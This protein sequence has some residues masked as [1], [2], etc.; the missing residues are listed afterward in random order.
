MNTIRLHSLGVRPE[1]EHFKQARST[2]LK[3][4]ERDKTAL[5]PA[6][7]KDFTI[8]MIYSDFLKCK[9]AGSAVGLMKFVPETR[10]GPPEKSYFTKENITDVP[11]VITNSFGKG[12]SVFIPWQLGS[13]YHFK[14]NYMHRALF[15]GAL[16]NILKADRTIITNASP[17]IE[18]SHMVNR[19]N[20]FE[21]IGL[22]NHS[23]Q[24]GGSLRE[25]VPVFN[26]SVRFKPRRPIK[27]IR[28]IRSGK[29]LEFKSDNGWV[30][31]IVPE[32]RDFE[33][34]VCYYR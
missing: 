29:S 18:M 14:G 16:Q 34:V 22:I 3:V 8:M 15:V 6:E 30:E 23:G 4:S 24:I 5:G 11:G 7:F 33:M 19:N 32:V 10:F 21:W 2:Y 20:A 26:T 17:L 12:K 1:Y 31:C 28:L 9:T 13:L 25:P 27:E